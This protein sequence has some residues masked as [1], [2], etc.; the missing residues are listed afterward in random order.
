MNSRL[1]YTVPPD[2]KSVF[3]KITSRSAPHLLS[4]LTSE[5]QLTDFWLYSFSAPVSSQPCALFILLGARQVEGV[6]AENR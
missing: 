4:P 2:Q 3:I 1:K 6:E 5:R